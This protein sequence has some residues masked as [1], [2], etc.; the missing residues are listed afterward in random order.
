MQ[1][2]KRSKTLFGFMLLA[3]SVLPVHG[4]QSA[5]AAAATQTVEATPAW[6]TDL[7]L[8][9]QRLIDTNG[10][11]TNSALRDRLL[12][13]AAL[14]QEARSAMLQE[15]KQ[16]GK[17]PDV[18]ELR[19]TDA[20]LTTE[21]KELVR[22]NGWPAIH[23]VG[24]DASNAAMLIL[25]HTEDHVW[26]KTLLPKLEQLSVEGKIDG[27]VLA[28]VVDKELVSA[29][30]LQRYGTQFKFSD[31]QIAMY[32]VEDPETLNRRRAAASL[33]PLDAYKQMLSSAY[34]MPVANDVVAA[35]PQTDR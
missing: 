22:S 26:Q 9:H 25:S 23:L 13:D 24:F 17:P 14:D 1:S 16:T 7:A 15:A 5:A 34:N 33:P 12:K 11:G 6:M 3:S 21:L 4:Q 31:K 28:L 2:A 10:P 29:G 18:L 32:A 30:K 20:K 35:E 27:S 8:H 19:P